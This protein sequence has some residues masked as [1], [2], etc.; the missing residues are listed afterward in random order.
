MKIS[1]ILNSINSIS[2][3]NNINLNSNIVFSGTI[4]SFKS[5]TPK[6][7]N[8]SVDL[9][10]NE[11]KALLEA[12]ANINDNDYLGIGADGLVY[13][14]N[15]EGFQHS[16][17]AKVSHKENRN[18][19]TGEMQR[20][21]ADFH[22]EREI[23]SKVSSLG[24]RSQRY[25]ADFTLKDGK[26]ILISTF[27]EGKNPNPKTKPIN[28]KSLNQLLDTL[29]EL[30]KKGI[31]HR[32]LKKENILIDNKDNI[33]LIDYGEAICFSPLD[34]ENN[35]K[36]NNFPE[37]IAP[38][39]LRSLEDTFIFP[40]YEELKKINKAKAEQFFNDYIKAKANFHEKSALYLKNL[41]NINGLEKKDYEH[42]KI[43][44]N[45]QT[46][47][48]QALKKPDSDI[49]TAELLNGEITYNSELAYKNEILLLN[50]LANMTLKM[51]SLIAAK[52]LEAF[53]LQQLNRP[54][55][56]EKRRYFQFQHEYALYRLQKTSS[57]LQG[58][59]GWLID[60]FTT[61]I[62]DAPD[63]KQNVIEQITYGDTL[64]NFTIPE[65]EKIKK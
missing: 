44:K 63:Y 33:G 1:P 50:P 47:M 23:L 56:C 60:C 8:F 31:L 9:K 28:Q 64:Q 45:Y 17:A 37:F 14:L 34:T 21:N 20:V 51:N 55:T 6:E 41:E 29:F 5:R 22:N 35:S 52:R 13:K 18:A 4:D 43:M 46:V 48:A 61:P 12:I 25:L 54:N 11:K 36:N 26:N 38:T 7:A 19:I 3:K 57:W 15:P 30:D 65:T 32:D 40:Y 27:I 49:M 42:L 10:D 58:L 16:V 39:N 59:T 62:E 53:S 2:D 24:E